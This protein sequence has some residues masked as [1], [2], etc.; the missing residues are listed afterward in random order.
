MAL[1]QQQF[2]QADTESPLGVIDASLISGET[3]AAQPPKGDDLRRAF[4]LFNEMSEQLSESYSLLED[5]VTELTQELNT[6]SA[7]RLEELAEKE[8]LA[9][10]LEN[11]LTVLP[12]GVVVLDARGRVTECNPAAVDMLGE[13]L[14]GML[15]RDVIVRSFAPRSDDG[16]EVSTKAGRRISIA[17]RSLESEGH[18]DGQIILLTDQ[19]E[20]RRLQAELS[21][22]ERLSALGKMVS[23]LAHQ[24]RTPLSAAMLYAGHLRGGQLKPQQQ[25]KF[26]DKL[27]KR[28][29]H[30]ERQ[31]QDM[32]M[33]VKGD[34]PLPDLISVAELQ[35][36][37]AEEMEVVLE[38]SQSR[39][40][41][42]NA[43]PTHMLRCN[44]DILVGALLNLVNNAIQAVETRAELS[45]H[46][47]LG[48]Q[49]QANTNGELVQPLIID[50]VDKG[51]GIKQEIL[52]SVTDVFMTT[53]AQGTGLGLS[54][55][56][57][58]M[59]AHGGEL[60]LQSKE[61]VG[62]HVRLSLPL[63]SQA[64][65]R[66]AS[67]PQAVSAVSQEVTQYSPTEEC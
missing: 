8:R 7:K 46:F 60:Q 23:A 32:L 33:F 53:K 57:T 50:V 29:N 36:S 37:L 40:L 49:A 59:R 48:E 38:T 51:P 47:S 56:Q 54:V 27:L 13:P 64:P 1:A 18:Q 15:W 52:N 21:R 26:S 19:T 9:N 11:L 66:M 31:V 3:D 35:E 28:L 4:Q 5:R 39:C 25:Q 24:I 14:E 30:M 43:C 16:H 42:R 62:T 6:V 58:V 12:G 67:D 22:H 17:T 41:W 65:E 63:A 44:Q 45:I 55:V 34:I 2:R 61:G 20:T 10:R